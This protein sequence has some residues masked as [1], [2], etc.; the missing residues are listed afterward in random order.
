MVVAV[1]VRSLLSL[2]AFLLG[3]LLSPPIAARARDQVLPAARRWPAGRGW[4]RETMPKNR[5]AILPDLTH[6]EMFASPQLVTTVLPFLNGQS[7]AKSWA[8]Q[9]NQSPKK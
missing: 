1:A 5:L 2:L 3:A 4:G 6:Y 8:E 9:V 7:K